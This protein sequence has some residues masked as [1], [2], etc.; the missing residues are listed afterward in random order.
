MAELSLKHSLCVTGPSLRA[1]LSS[2]Q[3]NKFRKNMH[4]IRVFARMSPEL[5]EEVTALIASTGKIVLYCG[6][7]GNDVGALKSAHLGVALLS[8]FRMTNTR[9]GSGSHEKKNSSME[10]LGVASSLRQPPPNI[11]PMWCTHDE[12]K[13]DRCDDETPNF[14]ESLWVVLKR[15]AVRAMHKKKEIK[16]IEAHAEAL[17]GPEVD[18]GQA[19]LAAPFT[20]SKPSISACVDLIKHGKHTAALILTIY[21]VVVL[22]SML[23]GYALSQLYLEGIRMSFTQK[24]LITLGSIMSVYFIEEAPKDVDSCLNEHRV[25]ESIFHPSILSSTLAQAVCHIGSCAFAIH[26]AKCATPLNVLKKSP[27]NKCWG[28]KIRAQPCSKCYGNYVSLSKSIDYNLFLQRVAFYQ[29]TVQYARNDI[30][31][32]YDGND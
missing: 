11:Q 17:Y 9:S 14:L 10:D 23:A 21:Q 2:P 25:P 16:S 8:G 6:D 29:A 28:K 18:I 32:I 27:N 30:I 22:E 20:S 5:K 3:R 12:M 19:S 26:S 4:C 7:G 24:V 31:R 13:E 15:N 1:A